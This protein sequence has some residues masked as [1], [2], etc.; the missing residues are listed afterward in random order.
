MLQQTAV[1][2]GCQE[3]RPCWHFGATTWIQITLQNI[4]SRLTRERV[5]AFYINQAKAVRSSTLKQNDPV[6]KQPH[7][8]SY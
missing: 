8:N 3:D 7:I 6:Y 4:L 5:R 2:N 1:L